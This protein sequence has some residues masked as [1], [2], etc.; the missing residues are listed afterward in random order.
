MAYNLTNLSGSS[1]ILE[2][3]VNADN[4]VDGMMTIGILIAL[5]VIIFVMTLREG[6]LVAF[7]ATTFITS[8][9]GMLF[10]L[11]G[12]IETSRL[13]WFIL[14]LAIVIVL[15]LVKRQAD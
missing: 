11:A 12:L 6:P 13:V 5:F 8:I 9:T 15:G 10:I 4:L 7:G 2:V 3:L 14:P 1:N